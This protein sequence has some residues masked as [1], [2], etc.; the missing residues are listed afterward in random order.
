LDLWTAAGPDQSFLIHPVK[1]TSPF[2]HKWNN[3]PCADPFAWHANS[4]GQYDLICTSNLFDFSTSASIGPSITFNKIGSAISGQGI[5][6]WAQPNSRWAPENIEVQVSGT[7]WNVIFWAQQI[8]SGSIHRIGWVASSKGPAPNVYTT[9]APG[10]LDLGQTAGGDIDAHVFADPVSG[11]HYLVWKTDDNNAGMSYTRI[12]AQQITFSF[13]SQFRVNQIGRPAVILDSTGLWWSTSWISGGSLI[14]GPEI[15]YVAPWYYLF[16]ASGRYCEDSYMEGAARSRAVM[17][18]Y[19]KMLIP[20]LTTGIVGN[21]NG[22]KLLGPGHASFLQDV[23]SK[24]WNSVWHASTG[25]DS[26]C[27]RYPYVSNLRFSSTGW[28]Y[29][30]F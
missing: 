24:V 15:I 20:L 21:A 13:D 2:T 19:E 16:F 28:P 30:D 23:S 27:V 29:S 7:A 8:G 4:T 14:E 6:S 22:Q 10:A 25:S 1:T 5:P 3:N 9:F 11:N 17:G 26:S 12:W 18:P